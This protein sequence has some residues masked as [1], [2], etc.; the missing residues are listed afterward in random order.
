[1]DTHS[2]GFFL[3]IADGVDRC[4]ETGGIEPLE[5]KKQHHPGSGKKKIEEDLAILKVTRIYRKRNTLSSPYPVP[6]GNE[7]TGSDGN[8]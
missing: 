4:A 2:F 1:M 5:E 6:V 3:V 8:P 7:F